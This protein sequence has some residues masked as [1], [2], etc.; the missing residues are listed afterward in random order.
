[1]KFG[2]R[3]PN[4][5]P[6]VSADNLRTLATTAEGLGYDSVLVHDHVL[7]PD[8]SW[9]PFFDPLVTLSYLAAATESVKL[10]TSVL[11]LP[12]RNPVIL[13][14]QIATLDQISNGRVLLGVG[15]GYLKDEFETMDVP[16]GRRGKITDEYL[17]V[18]KELW[19][20]PKTTFQ[21]KFIKLRN[22][23][24]YPKPIQKPHPPIWIG[25][26]SEAATIRA[27][28]FGNGR[29]A[30][31]GPDAVRKEVERLNRKAIILGRDVSKLEI[32]TEPW[33]SIEQNVNEAV[34]KAYAS[35]LVKQRW[36]NPDDFARANLI[37]SYDEIS[38]RVAAFREAGSTYMQLRFVSER[39]SLSETLKMMKQFAEWIP[40]LT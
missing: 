29:H 16:F 2:I 25:G 10:G 20:K 24:S 23:E 33:V 37:G 34:K 19:T 32:A 18:L 8:S 14:K 39:V 17:T 30:L 6:L 9:N 31:M 27:V 4:D 38:S 40:K 21:G 36:P 3:I 7:V 12:L 15:V 35:P 11:L 1:M 13:A 28:K 26:S 22:V 5:G